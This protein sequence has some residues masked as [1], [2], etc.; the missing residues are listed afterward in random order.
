MN[1]YNYDYA[2]LLCDKYGIIFDERLIATAEP[3]FVDAKLT[4]DQVNDMLQLHIII[5][6]W[7]F[8]RKGYS[9]LQRIGIA[10]YFLGLGK[11]IKGNAR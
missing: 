2:R 3:V 8:D 7:M 11:R 1:K 6:C 9:W 4:Q 10:L 5:V